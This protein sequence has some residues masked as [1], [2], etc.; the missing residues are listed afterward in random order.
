MT[1]L[2]FKTKVIFFFDLMIRKAG[3]QCI[4]ITEES[5]RSLITPTMAVMM[6]AFLTAL[7]LAVSMAESASRFLS[8]AV[9]FLP[10]LKWM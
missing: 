10:G 9:G 5:E 4:Q 3:L 7:P 1:G 2:D 6:C 8:M